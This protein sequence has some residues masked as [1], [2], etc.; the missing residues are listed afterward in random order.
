MFPFLFRS[1]TLGN[2]ND[3]ANFS[4]SLMTATGYSIVLLV[5]IFASGKWAKSIMNAAYGGGRRMISVDIPKEITEYKEKILFGLSIRQLICFGIAILSGVGTYFLGSK[6]I[7]QEIASYLVMIEVMPVFAIGFIKI[8]GFPFEKYVV[9]M[10]KHKFGFSKRKYRTNLAIDQIKENGEKNNK[11]QR[12]KL[13]KTRVSECGRRLIYAKAKAE[14]LDKTRMV[15]L[16]ARKEYE[17]I[18][19]Q[20]YEEL[21]SDNDV[22]RSKEERTI[23]NIGSGKNTQISKEDRKRT[24]EEAKRKIKDAREEYRRTKQAFK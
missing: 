19:K 7:G 17:K 4:K 22:N 14:K 23:T 2:I 1:A 20:P 5:S 24:R 13:E 18:K 10:Y 12:V 15:I 3:A 21:R 9:I 8:N 6:I 16:S 11:K